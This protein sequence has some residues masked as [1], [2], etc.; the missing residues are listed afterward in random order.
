MQTLND[1]YVDATY[2][3]TYQPELNPLRVQ[4]SLLNAGLMPPGMQTACELGVGQGVSANLHAAASTTH[5]FGNDFEPAHVGFAR[6]I[7]SA[8]GAQIHLSD[9]AFAQFCTRDDL[10]EFD[11]IGLHGVWSWISDRNRATIVDFIGRKLKVGGIVYT[12]YNSLPGW[13][14]MVPIRDLM[15]A[16]LE[17]TGSRALGL[18]ASGAAA[19]DFA[20][21]LLA[22]QPLFALAHPKLAQLIEQMKGQDKVYLSHEFLS[23]D[24]APM[25]FSRIAELLAPARLEFAC[26]ATYQDV[27][28]IR[29]L[30][31]EKQAMLQKCPTP[32]LRESLLDLMVNRQFRRDYWIKGARR[33]SEQE[34]L[35]SLRG[36]GVILMRLR[37]DV[38]LRHAG[39]DLEFTLNPAIC[40]PILDFLA[41][42]RPRT[43]G[44]IE[45]A[46]SPR[47][48]EFPQVVDLVMALVDS[49]D[50]APV[51]DTT[52]ARSAKKQTDRLNTFLFDKA[53]YSAN[54][55][56]MASP[57]TGGGAVGVDRILQ[58]FCGAIRDG[59]KQA[60]D[61]AA[62]TLP[63]CRAAGVGITQG[64]KL[65]QSP[66]EGLRELTSRAAF[67][68]EKQLTLLRA[69][70][71]V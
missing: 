37:H 38:S 34:R 21:E 58:F 45:A 40:N 8:S 59:R 56:L 3:H 2:I 14:A 5:W 62:Y 16:H 53:R 4:L 23:R 22:T 64:D 42:H 10:P 20:A 1:G 15:V 61:I 18:A 24:W 12:G 44:E 57:V 67:F 63:L 70:Q 7:A 25:S 32:A 51:H 31:P 41:D 11:L 55:S 6:E 39:Y 71:V 26:A 13:A 43:L 65:L 35:R 27:I 60:A 52:A 30:S 69:L 9:E 46:V 19:L 17:A 54:Y 66:E 33:L 36:I 68:L 50:L 48:I 28:G 49:G 29:T 47:G